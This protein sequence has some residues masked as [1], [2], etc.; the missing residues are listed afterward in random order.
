MRPNEARDPENPA[1]A[2]A[3]HRGH[4]AGCRMLPGARFQPR[5]RGPPRLWAPTKVHKPRGQDRLRGQVLFTTAV[6]PPSRGAMR[7]PVQRSPCTG[8]WPSSPGAFRA[9]PQQGRNTPPPPRGNLLR[10]FCPSSVSHTPD[11]ELLIM[12][13]SRNRP[14][15]NASRLSVA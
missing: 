15:N 11:L 13:K 14:E 12:L 4:P 5:V 9:V 10:G 8:V 2:G 7:A 3:P 1:P 6:R